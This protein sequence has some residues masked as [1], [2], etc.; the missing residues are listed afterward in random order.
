MACP[1]YSE[2]VAKVPTKLQ[3]TVPK[4]LAVQLGIRP[5]D[6]VDWAIGGHRLQVTPA[7]QRRPIL[8]LETRLQLFNEATDRQRRRERDAPVASRAGDRGWSREDL[9]EL[10]NRLRDQDP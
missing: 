5:G 4:P 3:V 1:C 9:Y 10:V 8:D 2:D 7:K 6:D